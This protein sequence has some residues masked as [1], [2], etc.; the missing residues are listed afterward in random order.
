MP[1][2]VHL[3]NHTQFS[4]L[5]G[6]T[7]I[8]AM[9]DKA[10]ADGQKGV[11]LTDH[12]N[13][14]GAFKF[15]AEANKRHIKPI[16]GCEF[17]LVPD[18]HQQSF[19][20]SK[21]EKD[22]RYHQLMLAKNKTGYE[23]LS[24]L[25]SLGFIEGM[26]S[27]YPRIDKELI[28]KHHEGLIATSC[29]IGAEIPQAILQGKVDKAEELLRWWVDLLGED[30]YIELQRHRGMED[31]DGTGISQED[32]NQVLLGFAKKYNLKVIATNDAHYLEEDDWKAHDI[33]LCVNTNAKVDE[34]ARF[35]F[36]S[37]DFYFK[38]REEMA[39]L[40]KDVPQALDHTLEIFDK[41]EAP[42]LERDILL[43]N[44]PLPPGFSDQPSYLRHL[45]YEGAKVRY[46]EISE[47]VRERLDLELNIIKN[48]GFDGYF[49]I[50]QDFIRAARK[51][52]V[53]VGPGRGSAAGSAVAFCL[54][55]TNI[56]PIKYN[57]LFERFLNPERISMPDIDIDFDDE[58]RQQVIDW[59]VNKYGRDQVA[60]IVTFG[61]MAARSSI[62]DV[63][64]VLALPLP[65]TDSIA[66]LV[67][68]RPN[69]KLKTILMK[70]LKEQ[71]S[72]WQAVE[73]NNIKKLN[74]LKTEEGLV[75]D[76]IRLAQK[77]EG[78]VRNTGIHAAGII[79]A[80]DDI[81]KYIPVCTSKESDLLV[82]QF[83]GSIVESAGMLKMD[84]LG[85]K[86]LSIIK[87]AIENIV[88]RF[89]EEAR[90]NP[91]D[92]P[93]DDPKTY[94][95]F[96]KGEMIG[97]FQFESDGMQKYLKE[98]KPTTIEDLIAM[99]ALYR[100]GP[101]DYIPSFISRK[102]GREKV[103]Y[104]HEWLA[105]ILK[106]TYGIMVYQ[107]QIMQTAQIMADYSLGKADMLRRAMGKKKAKEMA[108]HE[109]IFTEGAVAKGVP[110]EQAREIFQ[111]M[112]KFA[113][114]G[115]NRSH[116]A[117]Y[118]VLA[119]QTAWLKTHFPA[120]FMA[121]VLTHNKNDITKINFFLRECKRMGIQVLSPDINESDINFIVNKVGD[122][123]FGLSALKGIG[124]G[125]VEAILEERK[126]NGPFQDVIDLV[127]R[128]NLRA[129]NK[130]AFESLVLGGA[131][132]SFPGIHRAQYF[133]PSDK[134]DSFLEHILRFGSNFQQGQEMTQAS[135]F[136]H[137]EVF[138]MPDPEPP[139]ANE[140]SL[141]EKLNKEKE[142]TGI[143]ISGH[144]LD[145]YRLVVDNFT[146]CTLDK[147]EYFKG[148]TVKLAAFV[149][150]ADH[151]ISK[152]GTGWGIFTI[153]DYNGLLEI[154]LMGNDY[155]DYKA[156]L[157]PGQAVY[158]QGDYLRVRDTEEFRM[159]I[160]QVKHLDTLGNSLAH[161]IVL[162]L[163]LQLV[164]EAFIAQLDAICQRHK[165]KH[166]LKMKILDYQNQQS[167]DLV[168]K[169]TKINVSN[170]L[171]S[172]LDKMGLEY[173]LS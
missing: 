142:V 83:D 29:C 118:S 51:M 121:S 65:E 37:S 126:A 38:S 155:L 139:K 99:N 134:Y 167:M 62:R 43:P 161:S 117:A 171:I 166:Q 30:F 146:T 162:K 158:V 68:G 67:P 20:K 21:G 33:L 111:V 44:F 79:I 59:V 19:L 61:T 169:D 173:T 60:Q 141:L 16:V 96:Q 151:R 40:F 66:K 39:R 109:Q 23:N 172:D 5:D 107:E 144:P 119:Y 152:R 105:E 74:E 125:P 53:S 132:D 75:G 168:S 101:M 15:V 112:A 103:E 133:A 8:G 131:F 56:D 73:Y 157:E 63:G 140:W 165:G 97:I 128:L 150:S 84:F 89:G 80:P 18:R 55:I 57:L 50:V 72:D 2:F 82:T 98:L 100:P 95:L 64:R 49:L 136:S 11:A 85:L 24:K 78:S 148:Q 90:I 135:L 120:E 76:T 17:Y 110:E 9:M 104:P 28:V 149:T 106:P 92:I 6:A 52:G 129:V 170:E 47:L 31:I 86:T 71:E 14:F 88:N 156:R 153:Q 91:D 22:E 137:D 77:L 123:R 114:Y 54:T 7:E 26:Y 115:F 58:G 41:I 42:Q 113:S 27:K 36:P 81:K 32:V 4:L 12:G 154:M 46:G 122:I 45:V 93:L 160:T 13:M 35:K 159:K 25:C 145:D 70:T 163:P 164:D 143:F 124:E 130:K 10:H 3:H 116:A 48:M 1:D 108:M 138:S 94:E 69:T 127:K 102:H 34:E 87:D 147:L